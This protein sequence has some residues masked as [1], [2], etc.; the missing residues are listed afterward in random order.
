MPRCRAG[1]G[2]DLLDLDSGIRPVDE[3]KSICVW[4]CH[5][6]E[7][8]REFCTVRFCD[9]NSV[10]ALLVVL[11]FNKFCSVDALVLESC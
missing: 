4:C 7:H 8:H 5:S 6:G 2:V 9:D 11:D 10:P 3:E 1:M